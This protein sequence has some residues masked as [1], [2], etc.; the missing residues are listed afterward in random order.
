MQ[1]RWLIVDG[2][3]LLHRDP[4]LKKI[5]TR[6]LGTGRQQLVRRLEEVAASLADR[7]TIVFDGQ[8][9][10]SGSDSASDVVEI[11]FSPSDKTADTVI[12][13]LAVE[14]PD[15]AT[16]LV[17][18]SDRR[19]RETVMAAGCQ[20]MSGGEFLELCASHRRQ[21]LQRGKGQNRPAPRNTLGDFFPT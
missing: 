7:I 9:A 18:S 10:G 19:E 1:I 20:S 11:L 6:D 3:S 5:L 21:I 8:G 15:P 17:V 14:S 2:Y 16:T 12:E 13:R 4:E